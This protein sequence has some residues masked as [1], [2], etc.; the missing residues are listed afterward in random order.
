MVTGTK[1]E[2]VYDISRIQDEDWEPTDEWDRPDVYY[3]YQIHGIRIGDRVNYEL[4]VDYP[5]EPNRDYYLVVVN[6]D[7]GDS[8]GRDYGRI[9]FVHLFQDLAVAEKARDVILANDTSSVTIQW[10]SGKEENMYCCWI[11]YF[12]EMNDCDIVPVRL[13]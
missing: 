12:E 13:L 7:T 3:D 11:G 1:I 6:Y 4:I 9:A 10:D 8:F 5:V 2:V